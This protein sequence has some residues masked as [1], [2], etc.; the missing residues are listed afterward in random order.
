[1]RLE[2]YAPGGKFSTKAIAKS[3]FRVMIDRRLNFVDLCSRST[4]TKYS[5]ETLMDNI[6]RRRNILVDALCL[7][8]DKD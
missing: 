8:R 6:L 5:A 4:E 3:L 2:G 1:M 7:F